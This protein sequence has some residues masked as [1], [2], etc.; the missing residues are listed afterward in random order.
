MKRLTVP[1][2]FLFTLLMSHCSSPE[3]PAKELYNGIEPYAGNPHYWQYNGEPVM[4]L[5]GTVEDNLFQIENLEEHLDLLKASGGN[6]IRNTMSS[7]DEGNEKPYAMVDGKYDLDKFNPAYWEK[8]ENMLLLTHQRGIIPQIEVWA[9]YDFYSR[10]VAWAENPFNPAL[11]SNYTAAE[12][13]LPEVVDHTA[14][15]KLNPFFR[16]VPA[17]ANNQTVLEFQKKF[18]DK[19]LSY[20]LEYD[21]VLYSMDNETDA[22]PEWGKFW[23]G[24]IRKKANELG[25]TVFLTEMW[26]NWDPT[27]G[28]VPGAETQDST[29]HPFLN[30][31]KA[32]N[33]LEDTVSYDFLDIGNNNAQDGEMHYKTGLYMRKWVEK[34]GVIRPINNVKVY[35]GPE[36]DQW[37]IS[38][39]GTF[40]DGQERFWRNIFAG[41]ASTRFHRPP[42]GLGLSAMAQAHLKSSRMLT[43]ETDFF[44]HKPHTELLS[45]REPNEAFCLAIPGKEYVVLFIRGGEV[46]LDAP[47]GDYRLRW[48]DIMNS[49]WSEWSAAGTMTSITPPDTTFYAVQITAG[50]RD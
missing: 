23:A 29:T 37:S 35:G 20:T 15:E 42:H 32:R 2:L 43:D 49:S 45:G 10:V 14:Q 34:T 8:F 4:L 12:S 3:K 26:N 46:G 31:S 30:R 16:T 13:G 27:D 25:K 50:N 17:L 19:I 22:H 38:Y 48:L 1:F 36:W 40:V 24:Y 18:V 28:G 21:H 44:N 47:D 9:T 39:S 6:Y 5:G 41:H 11:N 7:R 33:T